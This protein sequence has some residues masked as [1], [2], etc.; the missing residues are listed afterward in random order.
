MLEALNLEAEN[1][2]KVGS[3]IVEIGSGSGI[4]INHLVSFLDKRNKS[5]SLALAIDINYDANILT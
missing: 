2:I 1:E 3:M 5:A 4:L